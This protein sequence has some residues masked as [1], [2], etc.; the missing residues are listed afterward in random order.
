LIPGLLTVNTITAGTITGAS[1][2]ISIEAVMGA[3]D[4]VNFYRLVIKISALL[5]VYI[6]AADNLNERKWN[7]PDPFKAF[8]LAV[9]PDAGSKIIA[10]C[11][12]HH[13]LNLRGNQI[14]IDHVGA[15]REA[16]DTDLF[17]VDIWQTRKILK[18]AISVARYFLQRP[19]Q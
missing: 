11:K 7:R 18:G 5:G 2:G 9:E 6:L 19:L 4:D 16:H 1:T 13:P 14:Y 3:L 10:Q 12:S 17:P 8:T 15:K